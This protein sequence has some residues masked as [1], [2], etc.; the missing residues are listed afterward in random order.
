[1]ICDKGYDSAALRILIR[2]ASAEPVIP[3]RK[4]V[5]VKE[6]IDTHLYKDRNLV[7]RFFNRIKHYRHLSS[8]YD[9]LASRFLGFLHFVATLIW[10][11]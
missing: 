4:N 8:R 9:K 1:V 11:R 7:E 3:F 10:L 5:R 2:S 6:E